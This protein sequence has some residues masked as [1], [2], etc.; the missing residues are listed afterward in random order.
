M[1]TILL[2]LSLLLVANVATA[3]DVHKREDIKRLIELMD[4]D[5]MIDSLYVQMEG[6][7]RNMAVEMNVRED[8]RD[9]FDEY[10]QKMLGI[11]REDMSWAKMQPGIIDVYEDN[12]TQKEVDDMLAFYETE[13]GQSLI[14]KMPL[15]MQESMKISQGMVQDVMPRI[16]QVA[17]ELQEK[18]RARRAGE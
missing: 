9:I 11:M 16:Q 12:F 2:M 8:E 13:T 14:K 1:K 10:M 4:M 6:M 17:T 7:M 3:T 18:L 5:A 15:L